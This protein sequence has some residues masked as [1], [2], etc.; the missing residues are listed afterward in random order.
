MPSLIG[1]VLPQR[2]HFFAPSKN[3][4]KNRKN[5]AESASFVSFHFESAF[6]FDLPPAFFPL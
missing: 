6:F 3:R 1:F 4:A 2:I 5:P